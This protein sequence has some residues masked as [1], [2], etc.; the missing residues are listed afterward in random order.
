MGPLPVQPGEYTYRGEFGAKFEGKRIMVTGASGFVG[1][2]LCDAL[3]TLGA[4]VKGVALDDGCAEPGIGIPLSKVDLSEEPL[5]KEVV[6]TLNPD[7]VF[8]L[9]GLV[10]TRQSPDLVLPT[11]RHNLIATLNIMTALVGTH[12]QRVVVI[13]SSETPQTG[14]GPNSPYAAS[15]TAMSAY[16][17]MYYRLF[18]V[19]VV[20]ARPHMVYGPHQPRAKLIPYVI[21][22]CLENVPPLLSSGRRI[23][24]PVYVKDVVRALL[25]MAREDTAVGRTLDVGMGK[26]RSVSEIVSRI[27]SRMVSRNEPVYGSVLDRVDEVPQVADRKTTEETLGWKPIWSFDEG[28]SETIDWYSSHR[29]S[30]RRLLKAME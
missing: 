11:L 5:A 8:N 7:V 23:C 1:T 17:E 4:E 10:D 18:G 21:R 28:L 25:L 2:N 15:K 6:G 22:C 19:P 29:G 16:C 20:I 3:A 30:S 9:A 12:C 26:G 27:L 24:D 14:Q 13:T